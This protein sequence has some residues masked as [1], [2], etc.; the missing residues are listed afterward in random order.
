MTLS[1]RDRRAVIVL[2]VALVI[3]LAVWLWPENTA[4]PAKTVAAADIPLAERRLAKLRQLAAIVPAREAALKQAQI[5]LG[6]R[7]KGIIQA[8]TAAQAQAQ[9]LQVIRRLARA[10]AP[11]LE[12][13]GVEMGPGRQLGGNYGEVLVSVSFS[14]RIDQLVNLLADI[15]AQTELLATE[16]L[17]LGGASSK[18]KTMTV[19]LTVAGLV[20]R[21]LI[22]EK[23]GFAF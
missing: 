21:K 13:T 18:Q 9:V 20:A 1:R 23:K 11:P 16:E 2:G 5:D 3:S 17:R 6:E 8:D 10:Q 4:A 15:T 14:A 22:P 7:E 12:L 19:R